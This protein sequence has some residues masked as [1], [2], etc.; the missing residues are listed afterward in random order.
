MIMTNAFDVRIVHLEP[1]RVAYA[2]GFGQEPEGLAWAKILTWAEHK[3][4]LNNLKAH[5]FLG[6]NNP[7]PAPGSPNYGYEQWMT[8]GPEDGSEGEVKVK[9]FAGG[10]YAVA[11]CQGPQNIPQAWKDLL[12]WCDNSQYRMAEHQC[13]EECLSTELLNFGVMPWEKVLFDLYLPIAE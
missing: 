4:W 8:V 5:R 10:L 6:F 3:G 12:V 2:L 13:L 1:L 11:R 9:D 7:N